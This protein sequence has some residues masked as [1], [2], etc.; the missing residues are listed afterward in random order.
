MFYGLDAHKHFIQICQVGKAGE[1][2]R[3]FRIAATAASIAAFAEKLGPDDQV[4][5]EATFHTWA[6]WSLLTPHAGRV[7]VANPMQVRAIAHARVKTD[8]IDAHI[9]AQL[10]R[11]DFIP[12]VEMP[13]E[14]IWALR[15]LVSH[16]RFLGKQR[17]ALRNR[18]R[19]LVNSRLYHCPFVELLGPAGRAW[20]ATQQFSGEE[21]LIL[22]SALR[23]HDE[24][25]EQME[26]LDE[27]LRMKAAQKLEVKL[28]MTIPG[29]NVAVAMGLVSC[30]GDIRRFKSPNQLASYFGLVPRVYQ[31]AD[32]CYHGRISKAGRSHGRWLAVEAAQSLSVSQSPLTA[33]YHRVRCKK[34]HNVAVTAL[35]RKLVVLAWHLLTKGEPYRY[36]PVARTRH[37]LKR[38]TP[39][40]GPARKGQVP[41]TIEAVYEELGLPQAQPPTA[42]ERRVTARNRRTIT[43]ARKPSG[44]RGL[45]ESATTTSEV[46]KSAGQRC[47]V[48]RA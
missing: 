29:V 12:E 15:E 9:L 39:D 18:I 5:L 17:V 31:S 14:E 46:R 6:I 1:R 4:V 42:G 3:D 26:R 44:T 45:R 36:A 23:L 32:K 24:V 47:Q 2:L 33:T 48:I 20:L 41:R 30:I 13:D 28:L 7:L 37:K 11:L 43:L 19:S 27:E 38:V 10:L 25:T 35:A 16:R 8:K 34:G 40:C 21:Q 22:E